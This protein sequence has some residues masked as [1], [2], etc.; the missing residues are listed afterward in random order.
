MHLFFFS[1][2]VTL[3]NNTECLRVLRYI[4]I[5][6]VEAVLYFAAYIHFSF[7]FSGW[8]INTGSQKVLFKLG[9]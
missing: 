2:L 6:N 5:C 9:N 4:K 3:R 1:H 8:H 7:V